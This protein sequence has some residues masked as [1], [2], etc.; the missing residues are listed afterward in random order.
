[1]NIM[2]IHDLARTLVP[3]DKDD[4]HLAARSLFFTVM[5]ILQF[6]N[7]DWTVEEAIGITLD[8]RLLTM[9]LGRCHNEVDQEVVA[10]LRWTLRQTGQIMVLC[11]RKRGYIE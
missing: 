7:E 4:L 1:M 2:Q 8:E 6:S 11:L 10:F 5:M 3:S 9:T